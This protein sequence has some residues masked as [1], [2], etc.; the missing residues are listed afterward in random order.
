MPLKQ[1]MARWKSVTTP[2]RRIGAQLFRIAQVHGREAMYRRFFGR[3]LLLAVGSMRRGKPSLRHKIE[4]EVFLA[5][6]QKESRRQGPSRY[7]ELRE[8]GTGEHR[9]GARF[10]STAPSHYAALAAHIWLRLT[11]PGWWRFI[12]V[13]MLPASNEINRALHY[14]PSRVSSGRRCC[15]C[16]VSHALGATTMLALLMLRGAYLS[17]YLPA[18]P[19]HQVPLPTTRF[20]PVFQPEPR[21]AATP[22]QERW[23]PRSHS[24]EEPEQA[25]TS[26]PGYYYYN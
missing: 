6:Y 25:T 19:P 7:T 16:C 1:A 14:C 8:A 12:R 5:T 21:P 24:Q 13:L 18:L 20:S 11:S 3:M 9:R 15:N 26:A 22:N 17:N 10:A 23:L 2:A 4:A